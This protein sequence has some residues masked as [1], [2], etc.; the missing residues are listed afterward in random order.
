MQEG[1]VWIDCIDAIRL[2]MCNTMT[3]T[4]IWRCFEK[5]KI[6][7]RLKSQKEYQSNYYKKKC[8]DYKI[9]GY[10]YFRYHYHLKDELQRETVRKRPTTHWQKGWRWLLWKFAYILSCLNE[11]EDLLSLSCFLWKVRR[12]NVMTHIHRLFGERLTYYQILIK[13]GNQVSTIIVHHCDKN[14]ILKVWTLHSSPNIKNVSKWC[15]FKEQCLLLQV[16]DSSTCLIME[17]TEP[18]VEAIMAGQI[19]GLKVIT[20]PSAAAWAVLAVKVCV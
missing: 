1:S 11:L 19:S 3:K 6:S 20:Q 7:T 10:A 2:C 12:T 16:S 4:V 5:N 9:F 18:R 13:I 17:I 14:T 15:A 8:R